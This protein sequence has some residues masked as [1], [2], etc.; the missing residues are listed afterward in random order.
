MTDV[1]SL[2]AAQFYR[3][4]VEGLADELGLR[5]LVHEV[6][7][8]PRSYVLEA[9][10]PADPSRS[11]PSRR[12]LLES[13]IDS[14]VQL[15]AI[16]GGADVEWGRGPRHVVAVKVYPTQQQ[17]VAVR[18][19]LDGPVTEPHV[20]NSLKAYFQYPGYPNTATIRTPYLVESHSTGSVVEKVFTRAVGVCGRLAV[21][22]NFPL[23]PEGSD[24]AQRMIRGV[25]ETAD[26]LRVE[27]SNLNWNAD[28]LRPV[29]RIKAFPLRVPPFQSLATAVVLL[30]FMLFIGSRREK[31]PGQSA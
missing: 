27:G 16:V 20:V 9:V 15:R 28:L 6:E 14:S 30:S 17:F 18:E 8:T 25:V 12:I 29:E 1:Y 31:T 26:H 10:L 7:S 23:F 5:G 4:L 3:F 2:P 24:I 13:R 22:L 11:I 21:R 19:M